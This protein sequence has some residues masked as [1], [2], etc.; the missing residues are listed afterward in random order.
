MG[1]SRAFLRPATKSSDKNAS[2]SPTSSSVILVLS[3]KNS[4]VS[5]AAMWRIGAV[6]V[7]LPKVKRISTLVWVTGISIQPRAPVRNSTKGVSDNAIPTANIIQGIFLD[8]G[9]QGPLLLSRTC[10]RRRARRRSVY[11][12]TKA[13]P[14]A[15]QSPTID[16]QRTVPSK[17]PPKVEI[18]VASVMFEI[19]KYVRRNE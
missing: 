9:F 17:S 1:K 12:T 5:S 18:V 15:K 7:C 11:A 16:N 4:K 10:V 14:P 8:S 13:I 2:R 3:W 19:W 6:R